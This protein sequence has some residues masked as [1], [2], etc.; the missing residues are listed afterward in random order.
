MNNVFESSVAGIPCQIV[1]NSFEF[2]HPDACADNRE[3]YLG[4]YDIEWEVLDRNGNTA[5]WLAIK[6]TD[7]DV[8]RIQE[9]AVTFIKNRKEELC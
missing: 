9:E 5:H 7:A 2:Y 6:L 3:D 1:I 4:G 8:S